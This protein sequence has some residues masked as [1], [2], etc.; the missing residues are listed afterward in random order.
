MRVEIAVSLLLHGAVAAAL[1]GSP[2]GRWPAPAGAIAVRLVE[3]PAGSGGDT[4][5]ARDEPAA[6][7]AGAV[8]GAGGD[9]RPRPRSG[10]VARDA[11]RRAGGPA[12]RFAAAAP[13]ESRPSPAESPRPVNLR[14]APEGVPVEEPTAV[15]P[16]AAAERSPT[17]PVASPQAPAPTGPWGGDAGP[18][19]RA[20]ERDDAEPAGGDRA[21]P[22]GTADT[23]A[24]TPGSGEVAAAADAPGG[25]TSGA[26]GPPVRA[27]L[28]RLREAT[29]YPEPARARG[30]EGTT[31]IRIRISAR[32][33]A[34]QVEVV[35]SSGHALLDRAALDAAR[36][37][38]PYP[39]GPIT[40]EVPVVF[41]LRRAEIVR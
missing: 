22:S 20:G 16:R 30:L 15:E 28:A 41:D 34:E 33:T 2:V 11:G 17:T 3:G 39:G 35:D 21:A 1:L 7:V 6:G 4:R 14:A 29:V 40:V 25:G 5:G 23:P 9:V 37:G 24:A 38:A 10:R 27:I 13:A 26:G 36:R 18:A 19:A 12:R 8:V 31:V 32:G